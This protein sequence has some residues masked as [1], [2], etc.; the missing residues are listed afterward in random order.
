M[1]REQYFF[2]M[3]GRVARRNRIEQRRRTWA[4]S[5]KILISAALFWGAVA[6]WVRHWLRI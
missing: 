2:Q 1:T 5:I 4:I 6:L 3:V